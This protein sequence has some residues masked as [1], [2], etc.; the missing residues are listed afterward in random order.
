MNRSKKTIGLSLLIL[1]LGALLFV[2]YRDYHSSKPMEVPSLTTVTL[3]PVIMRSIPETVTAY[4]TTVSPHSVTLKA[5]VGGMI[6]SIRFTSGAHVKAGQLLFTLRSNDVSNQALKLAGQLQTSQDHYQRL[7]KLSEGIPGSVAQFDL[8]KAKLQYSQDLIAYREARSIE[9]IVAPISG[10]ISDTSVAIGNSVKEGDVLAQIVDASSLQ[11]EY[12]LPSQYLR[13]AELGQAVFFYPNNRPQAYH[14]TVV[15]V[16]PLLNEDSYNL[17]LRAKFDADVRLPLNVFGKLIQVINAE[18]LVLAIPQTLV[19][20]DSEGFYVYCVEDSK[21]IKKYFQ[22]GEVSKAG[23][24]QILSGIPAQTMIVNSDS[25][26][27]S[28][29]Q[30]VRIAPK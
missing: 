18:Q 22:P 3:T 15:Y 20:T 1:L 2:W 4:G 24:I 23:L 26:V 6:S 28:P 30:T 25:S 19:Q 10:V 11:I 9:N 8:I 12:P 17:T 13:H 21:I 5:E 27:L 29:G 14:A 7:K 16:S